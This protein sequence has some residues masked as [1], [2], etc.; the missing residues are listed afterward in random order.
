MTPDVNV[1]V[2]ALRPDHPHH[3][4]A[5][6]WL[7]SAVVEAATGA[8]FT[9]MPMVV[10][11][12]LRLVTSAKIFAKPTAIKDAI[13][14]VDKILAEPGVVLATLGAEWPELRDLCAAKNLSGN[15]VPDAWLAA[16]TSHVGEHLVT[17][18]R[19]FK[20]LLPRGQSTVLLAAIS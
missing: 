8:R 17:F 1:L 5:S 13:S 7:E 12:Y 9:L 4:V 15:D 19:D 18:D 6:A 16:A 2:A 10:A 3:A 11:S 14:A 20:K